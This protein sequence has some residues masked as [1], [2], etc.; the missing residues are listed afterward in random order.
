MSENLGQLT[1]KKSFLSVIMRGVLNNYL[2]TGRVPQMPC[3]RFVIIQK[4]AAQESEVIAGL[5]RPIVH[6][7][8]ENKDYT[9]YKFS[10]LISRPKV[11]ILREQGR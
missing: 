8:V 4:T 3:H 10:K 2:T 5:E 9:T 6:S 7:N 11:A 1:L